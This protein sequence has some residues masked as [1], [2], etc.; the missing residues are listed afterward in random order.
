MAAPDSI[1]QLDATLDVLQGGLIRI[2]DETSEAL[3]GWLKTLHGNEALSGIA[4]ELQVLQ[5][6][7]SA[8]HR[9]AIAESLSKLSEQTKGAAITA[10]PDAQSKLFQLSEG[11]KMAAGQVS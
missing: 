11:L 5:D 4:Q 7:I 8:N 2:T 1:A 6:A 3:A 10:T 9:G